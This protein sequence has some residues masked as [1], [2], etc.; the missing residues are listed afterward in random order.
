VP[1]LERE[2]VQF[3]TRSIRPCDQPLDRDIQS[4]RNSIE[5]VKVGRR[6]PTSI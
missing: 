4:L 5:L 6:C 3:G 2:V 1:Q